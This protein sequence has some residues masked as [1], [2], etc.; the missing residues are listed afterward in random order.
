MSTITNNKISL[1]DGT[2]IAPTSKTA[3]IAGT[4]A[5]EGYDI[6]RETLDYLLRQTSDYDIPFVFKNSFYKA[7]RS[8]FNSYQGICGDD[9]YASLFV[10]LATMQKFAQE[11]KGLQ[12]TTDIHSESD[13]DILRLTKEAHSLNY[14]N[15]PQEYRSIVKSFIENTDPASYW[16]PISIIQVPAFLAEQNDMLREII[17][18]SKISGHEH[19]INVKK[20]QMASVGQFIKQQQICADNGFYDLLLTERGSVTGGK[21]AVDVKNVEYAQSVL[22]VPT[23]VD[24]THP[25]KAMLGKKDNMGRYSTGSYELLLKAAEQSPS[26]FFL[27]CHPNPKYALCD[28]AGEVDLQFIPYYFDAIKAADIMYKD[29][30]PQIKTPDIRENVSSGIRD[31]LVISGNYRHFDSIVDGESLSNFL[32]GTGDTTLKLFTFLGNSQLSHKQHIALG[33]K[34]EDGGYLSS[35]IKNVP[36]KFFVKNTSKNILNELETTN[37]AVTVAYFSNLDPFSNYLSD[38]R[39][40]IA[41]QFLQKANIIACRTHALQERYKKY[42]ADKGIN[43]DVILLETPVLETTKPPLPK[44]KD[45]SKKGTINNPLKIKASCYPIH[46]EGYLKALREFSRQNKDL[47]I[48]LDFMTS[49][50]RSDQANNQVPTAILEAIRSLNSDKVKINIQMYSE[51]ADKRFLT[52]AD[53]YLVDPDNV[54]S[55]YAELLN[56]KVKGISR[57]KKAIASGVPVIAIGKNGFEEY[58]SVYTGETLLENITTL[59]NDKDIIEKIT[60]DQR[61]IQDEYAP[62]TIMQSLL[63]QLSETRTLNTW[64]NKM[65]QVTERKHTEDFKLIQSHSE[66]RTS[67]SFE[68]HSKQNLLRDVERLKNTLIVLQNE[69]NDENNDFSRSFRKL[70][71]M[72]HDAEETGNKLF[73]VGS[74]KSGD[75]AHYASKQM[76]NNTQIKSKAY[77]VSDLDNGDYSQVN[78]G[79]FVI[80]IS[81][82]GGGPIAKVKELGAIPFLITYSRDHKNMDKDY[83]ALP[84]VQECGMGN[85]LEDVLAKNGI[86]PT[87]TT[88]GTMIALKVLANTP[89]LTTGDSDYQLKDVAHEIINP[90]ITSLSNLEMRIQNDDNFLAEYQKLAN[91]LQDGNNEFMFNDEQDDEFSHVVS[92]VLFDYANINQDSEYGTNINSY[93]QE[94]NIDAPIEKLAI[95]FSYTGQPKIGKDAKAMVRNHPGGDIPKKA[96]YIEAMITSHEKVQQQMHFITSKFVRSGEERK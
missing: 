50:P 76:R 12:I 46:W 60:S 13:I 9:K 11:I 90:M 22:H 65:E 92:Q 53:A 84:E 48:E 63:E 4:C 30:D 66:K 72:V 91:V 21:L 58:P 7:N 57:A 47:Y 38:E 33:A 34:P 70:V 42:F 75:V 86:S 67:I 68:E 45:L 96:G 10:Y 89:L 69:F 19:I 14:D 27:E 36:I 88:L 18:F 15:I 44:F 25:A 73:I 5:F 49:T 26:A 74:G 43:K 61:K 87:S 55:Q 31:I 35:A 23:I 71:K 40:N 28:G 39:R 94:M 24:I 17:N 51:E 2:I 1:S 52:G 56:R 20:H 81:N 85:E 93:L 64:V 16:D 79:D 77:Y 32:Q 6:A 82:S 41:E 95:L 62:E 37:D 78:E 59:L 29:L 83:I 54:S 80:A 3:V 8:T